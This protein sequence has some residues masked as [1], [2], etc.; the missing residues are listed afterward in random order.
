MCW[1]G[2]AAEWRVTPMRHEGRSRSPLSLGIFGLKRC[3]DR[4]GTE[5]GVRAAHRRNF[6]LPYALA[7]QNL[8]F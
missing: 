3:D 7:V 6:G 4:V 5:R 8:S 2:K 1:T